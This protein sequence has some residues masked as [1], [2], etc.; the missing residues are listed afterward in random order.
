MPE[1]H[2]RFDSSISATYSGAG[3]GSNIVLRAYSP[4]M[5]KAS[6]SFDLVP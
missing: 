3:S 2:L 6:S 1:T 5:T 4:M